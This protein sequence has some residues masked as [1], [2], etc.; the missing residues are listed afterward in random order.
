MDERDRVTA[1]IKIPEVNLVEEGLRIPR[2]HDGFMYAAAGLAGTMIVFTLIIIGAL[3]FAG[4]ATIKPYLGRDI[5]PSSRE[6]F[7]RWENID[8][9]LATKNL[10]IDNPLN[11]AIKAH[12]ECGAPVD[13]DVV[14][15]AR[16]TRVESIFDYI[17]GPYQSAPDACRLV[18][19]DVVR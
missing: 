6:E 12:L 8:E 15:P 9:G 16:S 3:L 1:Q 2:K 14:V 4:C 10:F 7:V 13:L 5:Q 18:S 19:F 11:V 17:R